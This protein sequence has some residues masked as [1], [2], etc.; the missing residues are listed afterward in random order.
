MN[1]K[2]NRSAG[3]SSKIIK[4]R[5]TKI[6]QIARTAASL[7]FKKGYMQV[8]TR[9]IAEACRISPGTLYY[10]IK[11]KDDFLKILSQ[12]TTE[13]LNRWEKRLRKEIAQMSPEEALRKT[14]R[15]LLL[16]IDNMQDSIIFWY[17]VSRYLNSEQVKDIMDIELFSVNIVKHVIE[18]GVK[19]GRFKTADPLVTAYNIVAM[20]HIW[21]LKR[22]HLH[23]LY[24]VEQ[25][26]ALLEDLAVSM[27]RGCADDKTLP[28]RKLSANH[29]VRA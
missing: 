13:D 28:R 9:E 21:V 18:L 22:W 7:F 4:L 1:K 24:T 8:T 12:I 2:V 25:Y 17:S 16:M 23:G 20:C 3:N 14:T 5:N 6:R 10:Y 15:E 19:K 27:A 29:R 26:A 11:A